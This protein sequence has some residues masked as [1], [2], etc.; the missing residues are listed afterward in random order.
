[1]K[2]AIISIIVLTAL[3]ALAQL[4]VTV[5]QELTPDQTEALKYLWKTTG[6][7]SNGIPIKDFASNYVKVVLSDDVVITRQWR[8]QRIDTIL[9]AAT[10]DQ[11]AAVETALGLP[12]AK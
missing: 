10:D 5:K 12:A 3:V 6:A 1:M 4:T 11:I 2:K 8:I 9:G 7:K